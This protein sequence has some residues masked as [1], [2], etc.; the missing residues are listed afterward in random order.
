MGHNAQYLPFLSCGILTVHFLLRQI[1][2]AGKAEE[3]V[4]SFTW[5]LR[6]TADNLDS[7]GVDLSG[8]VELEVDVFDN[9]CP[10]VIAKAVGIEMSLYEHMSV[11]HCAASRL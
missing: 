10:Y 1:G 6:I 4:L 11:Y 9:E 5:P 8:I 7:V 3:S 2:G